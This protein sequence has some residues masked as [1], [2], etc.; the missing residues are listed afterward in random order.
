MPQ[1]ITFITGNQSKADYLAKY[2]GF[3]VEHH[4][5]E[6]DELQSLDLREI[7]EHK[8]KQAYDKLQAPVLV[9]DVSLEFEA[10][11][12]LPGTFIK[13]FLQELSFDT[14]CSLVDGKTRNATAHCVFGYYDGAR[15]ELLEGKLGGKV[16][17][18]PSG[19][20]GFGWDKV[21][22]PDGY[23]VTRASLDDD[24]DRRTYLQIKPFAQLKAFLES[25]SDEN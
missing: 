14:I 10:L 21:F 18:K 7:V 22:I 2:L 1:K 9:E 25:I 19:D 23:T 6:L 17:E 16:A 5:L 8:A 3:T 24:D 13:F 11:G 15:L 4:K 20:N 12:R